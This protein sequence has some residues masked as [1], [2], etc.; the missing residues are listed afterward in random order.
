MQM[1]RIKKTTSKYFIKK[2]LN[3]LDPGFFIGLKF[4]ISISIELLIQIRHQ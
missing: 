1:Y 4:V 3:H 2:S